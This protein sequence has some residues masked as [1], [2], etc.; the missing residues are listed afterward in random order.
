MANWL[1]GGGGVASMRR[2]P[3]DS[4]RPFLRP[5]GQPEDGY[6]HKQ[7]TPN[8]RCDDDLIQLKQKLSRLIL[9]AE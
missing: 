4:W 2:C 1:A 8:C 6:E 7:T 3:R 9:G 5:R